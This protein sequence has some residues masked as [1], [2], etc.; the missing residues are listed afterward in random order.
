MIPFLAALLTV[1]FAQPSEIVL[2]GHDDPAPQ[3]VF[4]LP[5]E[6]GSVLIG[7]RPIVAASPLRYEVRRMTSGSPVPVVVGETDRAGML[8]RPGP[9]EW[10]YQVRTLPDGPPSRMVQVKVTPRLSRSTLLFTPDGKGSLERRQLGEPPQKAHPNRVLRIQD[11]FNGNP[12][13]FGSEVYVGFMDDDNDLDYI[14]VR[15]LRVENPELP[16]G[17]FRE[18]QKRI[19]S[20]RSGQLLWEGNA[21][22]G[23]GN[24]A[25]SVCCWN[26]DDDPAWELITIEETANLVIRDGK[27]GALKRSF[28]DHPVLRCSKTRDRSSLKI[29]NLRGGPRARDILVNRGTYLNKPP[30]RD[31]EDLV[32]NFRLHW[33][34]NPKVQ[35]AF[36]PASGHEEVYREIAGA[37]WFLWESPQFLAVNDSLEPLWWLWTQDA[38]PHNPVCADLDGDGRDEVVVSGNMVFR[39]DG[40]GPFWTLPDLSD[41]YGDLGPG[42]RMWSQ[43]DGILIGDWRPDRPGLEL[44]MAGEEN[45]ASLGLL[46]S[47][48]EILWYDGRRYGCERGN[49][50][51]VYTH[52]AAGDIVPSV[53]GSELVLQRPDPTRSNEVGG[54]YSA[55]GERLLGLVPP[56]GRWFDDQSRK[57]ARVGAPRVLDWRG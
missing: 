37:R 4:A 28:S 14:G 6:D 56:D 51:L 48:G 23:T 40:S 20:G 19:F 15:P 55:S 31:H 43:L 50:H 35:K 5:A 38:A 24:H 49:S 21:Y 26:V 13:W 41:Q 11:F 36:D 47:D 12:W 39:G 46:G 25:Q 52:F 8:D 2:R 7:W 32:R 17:W 57:G 9:G 27:T 16:E 42:S 44:Y 34:V 18:S 45:D 33:E 29:C 3:W 22:I 10:A 54:V 30:S 1:M 53:P